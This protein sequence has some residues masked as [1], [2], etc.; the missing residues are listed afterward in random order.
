MKNSFGSSFFCKTFCVLIKPEIFKVFTDT[1]DNHV[2]FYRNRVTKSSCIWSGERL[3][4]YF[5]NKV[6][7]SILIDL[8]HVCLTAFWGLKPVTHKYFTRYNNRYCSMTLIYGHLKWY[9]VLDK[10]NF[11]ISNLSGTR[12]NK[13]ILFCTICDGRDIFVRPLQGLIKSHRANVSL[14]S[15]R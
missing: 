14:V 11:R 3:K 2:Q 7:F 6:F 12:Y 10:T 4:S 8:C 15:S 9:V 1:Q 13:K 5:W